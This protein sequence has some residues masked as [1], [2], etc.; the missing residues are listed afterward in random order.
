MRRRRR[1]PL[2]SYCRPGNDRRSLVKAESASVSPEDTDDEK[3]KEGVHLCELY[4]Q[5]NALLEDHPYPSVWPVVRRLCWL[6]MSFEIPF[7][8]WRKMVEH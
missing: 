3:A 6:R 7:E 5:L 1:I 4:T 8:S 2:L